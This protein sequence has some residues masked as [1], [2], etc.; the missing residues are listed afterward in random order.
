MMVTITWLV[1]FALYL[2]WQVG[3]AQAQAKAV[4]AHFM[5]GH[6]ISREVSIYEK[7]C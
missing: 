6:H 7:L 5:V 3:L 1:G 2:L 4:F